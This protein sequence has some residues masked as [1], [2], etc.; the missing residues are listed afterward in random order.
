MHFSQL[1]IDKIY[2]L[3]SG[4]SATVVKD[5][6][7]AIDSQELPNVSIFIGDEAAERSLGGE[8]IE[9]KERYI[10]QIIAGGYDVTEG[11]SVLEQVN[12][13]REEI[14]ERLL[15]KKSNDIIVKNVSL[16]EFVYERG[17]LEYNYDGQILIGIYVMEFL[18]TFRAALG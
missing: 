1:M 13:L 18:A 16:A 10:V 9:R 17:R 5:R 15:L 3:L 8:S 7:H 4:I 14:E 12:N 6:Y 2:D 11:V